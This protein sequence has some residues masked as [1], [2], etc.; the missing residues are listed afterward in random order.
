MGLSHIIATRGRNGGTW[1]HWQ[2]AVAYAKYLSPEFH[3]QWNEYAAAYLRGEQIGPVLA[4]TTEG[5]SRGIACWRICQGLYIVKTLCVL[6]RAVGNVRHP[7]DRIE[8]VHPAAAH[9]LER[10]DRGTES[11]EGRGSDELLEASDDYPGP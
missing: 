8:H 10:V 2:V 6:V 4:E 9:A 7:I 3:I 5:G 1:G 11:F